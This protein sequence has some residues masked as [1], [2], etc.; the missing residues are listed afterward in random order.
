MNKDERASNAPPSVFVETAA[1]ALAA[2]C[3]RIA[4]FGCY[5]LEFNTNWQLP[6]PFAGGGFTG[7][8]CVTDTS[9]FFSSHHQLH[10]PFG[11]TGHLTVFNP[12]VKSHSAK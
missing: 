10:Q 3:T 11:L 4:K 5:E 12:A 9:E 6:V 1:C 2:A 7:C 8:C